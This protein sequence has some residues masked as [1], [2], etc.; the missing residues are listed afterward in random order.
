[1]FLSVHPLVTRLPFGWVLGLLVGMIGA[2]FAALAQQAHAPA[3]TLR[4]SSV[5]QEVI[6][7]DVLKQSPTFIQSDS[8]SGQTDVKTVLDGHVMLRRGNI[9]LKADNVAYDP[10]QDLAQARGNVTVNRSG[11]VYQGP[12]LDLRL[13]AFEGF[14]T[15]PTYQLLKNNAYGKAERI[16]FI[17]SAHTVMHK[18]DLTTCKRKPGPDW[19]PD[20]F[21]K[22]DKITL[23]MDRNVGVAEGAALIFKDVPI[24]PIPNVDFPLTEERKSG[25]LPPTIGIDNIGGL[26]YTQPYYV[27]LAPNRDMTFFPTYWTRRGLRLGTEFRY[28]ESLSPDRP[29]GGEA[30]VDYMERDLLRGDPQ[31]AFNTYIR[32]LKSHPARL[33]FWVHTA[34]AR[35]KM[36]WGRA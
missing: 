12:A 24:L 22:A 27:N 29:F 8:L 30:R 6:P 21:F 26:E 25:F 28:L 35:L 4:S 16:D 18:A 33:S 13:D 31:I 3:L 17:D 20:W 15:Q 14:F 23:D 5:L 36:A 32:I 34:H 19:L 9:L 2:N 10:I 1:M 11:N 7:D